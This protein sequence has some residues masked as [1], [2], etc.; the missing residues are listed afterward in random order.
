MGEGARAFNLRGAQAWGKERGWEARRVF[1]L[2]CR[3]AHGMLQASGKMR[4]LCWGAGT[5]TGAGRL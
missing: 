4:F 3:C 5:V 1:Q 2:K